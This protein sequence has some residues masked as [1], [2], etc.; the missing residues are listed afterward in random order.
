MCRIAEAFRGECWTLDSFE[1]QERFIQRGQLA[2]A[3]SMA[4]AGS[5]LRVSFRLDAEES[6]RLKL[7]IRDVHDPRSSF[8]ET[9]FFGDGFIQLQVALS[10][11]GLSLIHI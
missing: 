4:S 5:G 1:E 9:H 2:L 10:V 11:K 8:R 6:D 7:F 3:A